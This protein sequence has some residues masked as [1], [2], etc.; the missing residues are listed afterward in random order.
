MGIPSACAREPGLSKWIPPPAPR[1]QGMFSLRTENG[2]PRQ[3]PDS[4]STHLVLCFRFAAA[5]GTRGRN[6]SSGCSWSCW[7]LSAPGTPGGGVN[8]ALGSARLSTRVRGCGH[9]AGRR[10]AR[11]PGGSLPGATRACTRAP[12]LRSSGLRRRGRWRGGLAGGDGGGRERLL[13]PVLGASAPGPEGAG[14]PARASAPATGIGYTGRARLLVCVEGQAAVACTQCASPR[15]PR[16][17]AGFGGALH[18]GTE[19]DGSGGPP[20]EPA[21]PVCARPESSPWPRR[22]PHLCRAGTGGCR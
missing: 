13:D 16:L 6:G 21:H 3:G 20:L 2:G 8:G 10:A 1:S 7:R 5:P 18:L 19:A 12:R 4:P 15:G 11:T 9:V 17:P 22:G 14:H